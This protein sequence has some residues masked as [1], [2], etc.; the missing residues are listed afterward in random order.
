VGQPPNSS[1]G[2]W[3]QTQQAGEPARQS[4][5]TGITGGGALDNQFHFSFYDHG[6]GQA[7][8]ASVTYTGAVEDGLRMLGGAGYIFSPGDFANLRE[9]RS[10]PMALHFRTSGDPGTGA[11][12]GHLMIDQ[13]PASTVPYGFTGSVHVGETN[14]FESVGAGW[15]HI[16]HEQ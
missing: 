9:W 8:N 3:R 4:E 14:P 15:E 16:V 11:N 2:E 10:H 13:I 12:S 5:T 7:L 6:Q 1:T